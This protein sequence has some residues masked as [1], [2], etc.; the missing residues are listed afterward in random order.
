[1][2]L[3]EAREFSKDMGPING[4]AGLLEDLLEYSAILKSAV[5]SLAIEWNKCMS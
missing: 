4:L 5:H 3:P 2:W 1:M